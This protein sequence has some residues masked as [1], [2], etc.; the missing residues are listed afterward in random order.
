MQPEPDGVWP[1]VSDFTS[2][3]LDYTCTYETTKVTFSVPMCRTCRDYIWRHGLFAQ[4]A[5]LAVG[6]VMTVVSLV[7]LRYFGGWLIV[8]P[9]IGIAALVITH[10]YLVERWKLHTLKHI[11]CTTGGGTRIWFWNDDYHKLYTGD[12]RRTPHKEPKWDEFSWR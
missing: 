9:V 2:R 12:S 4:L 10:E 11:A 6:A 5:A 3:E 8:A 1:V 7:A